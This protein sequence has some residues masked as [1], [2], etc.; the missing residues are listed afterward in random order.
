MDVKVTYLITCFNHEEFIEEALESAFNQTYKN[1]DYIISDDFSSD[2]SFSIIEEVTRKYK[3]LN[4]KINRNKKNMG[5]GPHMNCVINQ[6][7]GD[8]IVMAAGD[9]V[10]ELDRVSTLVDK[11]LCYGKPSIIASSLTEIDDKGRKI[12][13]DITDRFHNDSDKIF[14]SSNTRDYLVGEL[15]ACAGSTM[16]YS[17]TIVKFFGCFNDKIHSED[18]VYFFRGLIYDKVVVISES[19]VRYRRTPSSFSAPITKKF[20][21]F[22]SPKINYSQDFNLLKLNQY[23][24]D[25]LKINN[26]QNDDVMFIEKLIIEEDVIIKLSKC[27]LVERICLLRKFKDDIL[28]SNRFVLKMLVPRVIQK[29]IFNVKYN[30]KNFNR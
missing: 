20:N 24:T 14:T 18:I 6:A 28:F 16:A 12:S 25:L 10:S 17:K 9:D 8:L 15:L 29:L 5:I 7:S 26:M 30:I 11:W 27:T 19:L 21:I 3:Y 2:K 1:I 22:S 23:K 4:I 13:T